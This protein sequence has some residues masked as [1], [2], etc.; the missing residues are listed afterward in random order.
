MKTLLDAYKLEYKG[1]Q[2]D[3]LYLGDIFIWK[4]VYI[5]DDQQYTDEKIGASVQLGKAPVDALNALGG[6]VS[7]SLKTL[8]QFK[9]I[10]GDAM[11]ASGGFTGASTKK[12]F[13]SCSV[14]DALAAEGGFVSVTVKDL[15]L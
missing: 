4:A 5:G 1:Q 2:I 14:A 7:A 8:F 9:D 6:F 3:E 12:L 13:D 11:S 15:E 10:S